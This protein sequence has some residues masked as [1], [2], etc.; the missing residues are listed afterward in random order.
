MSVTRRHVLNFTAAAGAIA[1]AQ[2]RILG[3][4]QPTWPQQGPGPQEVRTPLPGTQWDPRMGTADAEKHFRYSTRRAKVSL[5]RGENRRKNIYEALLAIDEQIR[6]GLKAKKYVLIKPNGINPQRALVSTHQDAVHGILDY[7]APRFKGPVLI[8]EGGNNTA[9]EAVS[10]F[11]WAQVMAEHKPMDIKFEV[12]NEDTRH[13]IFHG[14]DYDLHLI[15]IR[16]AARFLDPDAFLMCSAVMKTHN[17]IV[18][19]LSI[20]NVVLGAALSPP[21]GSNRPRNESDKRKFHVGIRQGNYN[22]FLGFQ[23][24]M[25]NW[26]VGI[27]DGF[28]GMEG[29]GPASGTPVPH[30]IA[31][32]STDFLAVDRV[33]VECM[34][35]DA[36]WPGYLNYSYQAGLGQYDLAKIDVVGAK[37]AEVQRKY[38]LHADVDRML[39]WRGPMLDLPPNLGR[40]RHP[41]EEDLSQY[42]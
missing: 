10:E 20:K 1:A 21:P 26:G 36:G 16:L 13:E 11:G 27:I 32:A 40:R 12:P 15:P 19:T 8:A 31:L 42:A 30:R 4:Q 38:R 17:M 29:N 3:A 34:G 28:E 14:I 7:L 39:E 25:A 24:M 18:A 6:P 5:I 35:I 9:K 33:G 22:L 41:L 23:R 37:I 2:G